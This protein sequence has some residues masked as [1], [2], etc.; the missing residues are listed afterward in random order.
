M[1][2]KLIRKLL[3][4]FKMKIKIP[5]RGINLEKLGLINQGLFQVDK[6]LALR[7]YAVLKQV[8]GLDCDVDSFRIDRRGLS[9]ELSDYFKKKYP[10]RFEYGENYLNIR[11]ANRYMIV[12]SP[13]QKNA[14]LV[15]PQTSYE[16]DLFD[17]VHRQAKDTIED[18]TQEEAMF[19][20]MQNGIA[21]FQAVDDLLHVRKVELSL[22][23]LNH[24]LEDIIALRK[25]SRE[26]GEGANALD[27]EYIGKMKSLVKNVGDVRQRTVSD[28]FPIKIEAHS[29]YVEFFNG[30]HC[31]RNFKNDDGYKVLFIYNGQ[32]I[33]KESRQQILSMEL[34]D[35]KLLDTLFNYDFL[36][37]NARLAE[38]RIREIENQFLL[39][40]GIDLVDLP[41]SERERYITEHVAQ[42]PLAWKELRE[43]ALCRENTTT[44]I[45]K[46]VG[47]MS[48]ETRL[49][50]SEP[51]KNKDVLNHLLGELD[52]SDVVRSYRLNRRK[53]LADFAEAPVHKRRYIAY[54]LLEAQT[55]GGN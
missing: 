37:Y 4:G 19:G 5:K 54:R 38:Q 42:F 55:P 12:V 30:V 17:L 29:F 2:T 43:V 14:P 45:E 48:Y 28:I 46:V 13:D 3:E 44:K 49:K 53:L 25:L 18:V 40:K 50:L 41:E 11:S 24:T 35:K 31:L 16:N 10:E 8:F 36:G 15:A 6:D 47:G 33:T 27:E 34:Q 21:V 7:Y 39:E 26:L 20:Q 32:N 1:I 9:P 22:D 23:T 52:P 51:R